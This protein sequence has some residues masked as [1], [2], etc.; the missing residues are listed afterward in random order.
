MNKIKDFLE[1]ELVDDNTTTGGISFSGEK[2]KD[3]IEEV[4][5]SKEEDISILNTALI[6]CGIEPIT[7][8]K[9]YKKE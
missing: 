7:I 4:E 6:E 2:V 1:Y 3:F 8:I 5:I 9:D